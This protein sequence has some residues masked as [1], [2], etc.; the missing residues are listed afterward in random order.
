MG[1]GKDPGKDPVPAAKASDPD[2]EGRDLEAK[3]RGTGEDQ[4]T[5][6][7]RERVQEAMGGDQE[8]GVDRDPERDREMAGVDR[9]PEK[10]RE[11]AGVDRDPE[12]D[13]EMGGDQDPERDLEKDE[14]HHLNLSQHQ[15]R[16]RTQKKRRVFRTPRLQK[17]GRDRR[18]RQETY[19]GRA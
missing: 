18:R 13:R 6:V 16:V 7:D 17:R 15:T 8:T 1:P 14:I 9:D 5:G 3:D 4:E 11:M 2:P 12:K 19:R 10:D